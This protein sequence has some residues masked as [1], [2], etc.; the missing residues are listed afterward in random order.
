MRY[1]PRVDEGALLMGHLMEIAM[2]LTGLTGGVES[3]HENACEQKV[4]RRGTLVSLVN[5]RAE[6]RETASST[7]AIVMLNRRH[8]ALGLPTGKSMRARV[9]VQAAP[10]RL[11]QSYRWPSQRRAPGVQICVD[12][13]S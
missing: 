2:I 4:R 1:E 3:D 10:C 9:V 6:E 5:N 12:G 7:R 13:V 11:C 8:C